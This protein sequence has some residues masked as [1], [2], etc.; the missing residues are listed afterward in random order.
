MVL[1]IVLV[2]LGVVLVVLGVVLVVLGGVLVVLE[3]VLVVPGMVLLVLGQFRALSRVV[4]VVRGGGFGAPEGGSSSVSFFYQRHLSFCRFFLLFI[5]SSIKS[6]T[7]H[8][9]EMMHTLLFGR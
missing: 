4:L 6:L 3:V 1:G 2:V 8:S 7:Q 9:M 5:L